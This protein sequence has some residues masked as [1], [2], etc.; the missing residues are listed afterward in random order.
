MARGK[1]KDTTLPIPQTV[2][3]KCPGIEI[4]QFFPGNSTPR[5]AA[6]LLKACSVIVLIR[7]TASLVRRTVTLDAVLSVSP[8]RHII[9]SL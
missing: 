6:R 5:G 7:R 3:G 4:N 2:R 1:L 8:V 9:R